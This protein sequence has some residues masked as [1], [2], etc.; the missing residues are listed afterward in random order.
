MS[1]SINALTTQAA[2]D[3]PSLEGLAEA[4]AQHLRTLGPTEEVEREAWLQTVRAS[5]LFLA[6][7]CLRD[8]PLAYQTFDTHCLSRIPAFLRASQPALS[9]DEIDEVQQTLREKLLVP[10]QGNPPRLAQYKG[11][12][13]LRLWVRTVALRT[14]QNMRRSAVASTS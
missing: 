8:Y 13:D 2:Q 9:D 12:G 14:Q 1:S 5:D 4:F 7:A 6:Y 11:E 10:I 3:W